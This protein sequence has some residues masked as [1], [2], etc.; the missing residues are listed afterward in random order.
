MKERSHFS[1]IYVHLSFQGIPICTAS[2]IG[3]GR[4]QSLKNHLASIHQGNN[5][6]IK[7]QLSDDAINHEN[8]KN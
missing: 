6:G 4:K 1:A 8:Q 5:L 7:L 2:D 3:F